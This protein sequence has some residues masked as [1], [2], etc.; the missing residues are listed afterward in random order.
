MDARAVAQRLVSALLPL[1]LFPLALLSFHR[2]D[3]ERVRS[4]GP[5]ERAGLTAQLNVLVKPLTR[6]IAA[7]PLIGRVA[8]DAMLTFAIHPAAA[9]LALVIIAASIASAATIPV[10]FAAA[11]L[12]VA[13]VASRETGSG[14]TALSWAAPR[15]REW[16]VAWKFGSS[17]LLAGILLAIPLARTAAE[18]P[19]RV[20]PM[21]TGIVLI[22]AAATALGIV[23]SN[24]KT[25]IVLFLTFWYIVVNDH[26]AT[27]TLDFA[28]W[29]GAVPAHASAVYAGIAVGLLGVAAVIHRLK[30]AHS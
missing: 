3:P 15:L 5:S 27:P 29:F 6:R 26:G 19:S 30:L 22:T 25:F 7:V 12:L 28:G 9:I 16:F 11:A 2:F 8:S 13:D 10:T 23:T 18:D 4:A 20:V 14:T 24:P 17:L 1:V 21:L